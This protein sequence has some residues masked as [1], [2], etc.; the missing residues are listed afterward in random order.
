[1]P[2]HKL[3]LLTGYPRKPPKEVIDCRA[4]FEILEQRSNRHA[5]VLPDK[6]MLKTNGKTPFSGF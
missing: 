3:D 5:R 4:A 1:M 6:I 2:E